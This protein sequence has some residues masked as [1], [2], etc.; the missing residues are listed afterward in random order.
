[1]GEES[2]AVAT[3]NEALI[4][5]WADKSTGEDVDAGRNQVPILRIN[6]KDADCIHGLGT[7]VV[8]LKKDADD[9]IEDHGHK[10]RAIVVLAVRNRYSYYDVGDTSKN[11]SS[12]LFKNFDEAVYGSRYKQCCTDKSC[13]MRTK[14]GNPRCKAQKMV[15]AVAVTEA[16]ELIPCLAYMQ[17]ATYMPFA[18]YIGDAKMVK[19]K[20]GYREAP[21]YAFMTLLGTEKK[22]NG[23]VTYWEGTFK[24][25]P[26]FDVEKFEYFHSKHE[27]ALTYIENVNR[28]MA[29]AEEKE[30]AAAATATASRAPVSASSA[31]KATAA[32]AASTNDDVIDIPHIPTKE[33]AAATSFA[34]SEMPDEDIPF[35]VGSG[36]KSG[37]T[38]ESAGPG[39]DE[40]DIEAAISAALKS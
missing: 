11:C 20:A 5:A 6:Q 37:A 16:N 10:V 18:N 22:K 2:K 28:A 27:E 40:F 19:T 31:K 36:S 33:T 21:T 39:P 30:A 14:E 15:M 26:F 12:P 23:G 38:P 1:M 17:G 24:R 8:G 29:K 13:A 35:E 34:G 3:V 4:N 7:W 25:G 9:N 32:T